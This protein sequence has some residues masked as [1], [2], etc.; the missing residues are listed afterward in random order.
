VEELGEN[1]LLASALVMVAPIPAFEY[2]EPD[3]NDNHDNSSVDLDDTAM[4][5]EKE[6]PPPPSQ[7]SDGS[8]T[9]NGQHSSADSEQEM[10]L[11][12]LDSLL[13]DR[14]DDG[15]PRT[16]LHGPRLVQQGDAFAVTD[17]VMETSRDEEE[18]EEV[19]ER[20]DA[21]MIAAST[22]NSNERFSGSSSSSS[23]PYGLDRME[24]ETAI[25]LDNF[26]GSSGVPLL[27]GGTEMEESEKI[28]AVIPV[29]AVG[30]FEFLVLSSDSVSILMVATCWARCLSVVA[31]LAATTIT[32]NRL[33][34]SPRTR[35]RRSRPHPDGT[36]WEATGSNASWIS[37]TGSGPS[38]D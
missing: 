28:D 33:R 34:A 3:E 21:V 32:R 36:P 29:R 11:G 14:E 38:D 25:L 5:A 8:C 15:P 26:G 10:D 6:P 2:D 4:E 23:F 16:S 12:G 17:V 20:A 9:K 13:E 19:G 31:R 30:R 1:F 7:D 24:I 27:V 35:R 18:A 37:S 22:A